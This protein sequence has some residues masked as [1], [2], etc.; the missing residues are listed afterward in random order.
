MRPGL[1]PIVGIGLSTGGVEPLRTIFKWL[2]PARGMAFVVVP[3]LSPERPNRLPQLL[4]SWS[5]MP[6]QEARAG[7][8]VEPNHIYVVPP[9]DELKLE[10]ERFCLRPRSKPRAGPMS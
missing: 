2:S 6:V 8:Q 1:V 7:L 4:S 5:P 10:D 3:H 9:G